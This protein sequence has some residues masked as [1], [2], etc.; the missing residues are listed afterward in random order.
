MLCDKCTFLFYNFNLESYTVDGDKNKQTNKK[1]MDCLS[2]M[3]DHDTH[4]ESANLCNYSGEMTN[5]R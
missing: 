4:F 5:K 1:P 3:L 2:K